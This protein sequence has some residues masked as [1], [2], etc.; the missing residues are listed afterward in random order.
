MTQRAGVSNGHWRR[1]I[2]GAGD[3]IS[4]L[5]PRSA[6]TL[7]EVWRAWPV[8]DELSVVD[9][10]ALTAGDHGGEPRVLVVSA[11]PDDEVLGFGG[12]MALLAAAGVRL[13]LVSVTDGEASHP[14]SRTP[15]AR[16]LAAVRVRELH[17]ALARLGVTD[18]QSVRLGVPDTRVAQREAEMTEQLSAMLGDCSLCVAPFSDDRHPDHDAAGRAAL[19]A[20]ALRG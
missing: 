1:W 14:R 6:G 5:K 16:N 18:V 4:Q 11:H 12:T 15:V 20:G 10:L 7:E 2:E 8:L 9:P 13:R 3:R 17:T 19:A